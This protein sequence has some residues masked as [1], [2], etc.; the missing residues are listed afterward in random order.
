MNRT[1]L[2]QIGVNLLNRDVGSSSLFGIG[3]GSPGTI[4]VA[5]G[6][7]DPITG[8]T[9]TTVIGATFNNIVGGTT[10][11][12]FGHILGTDLLGTLDL[13]A[14]GRPGDDARRAEP[15]RAVGR[16]RELPRRRRIPDPG[17]A[18]RSAR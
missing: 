2:K 16:N 1:A 13:A 15:D 4:N 3:Q 8:V 14:E 12:L 5:K 10:L 18:S 17:F 6:A 9:P 11:G 7:V